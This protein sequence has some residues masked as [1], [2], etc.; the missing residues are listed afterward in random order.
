ML[1]STDFDHENAYRNL[2]VVLKYH[3][4]SR[5]EHLHLQRFFLHPMRNGENRPMTER[6][7]GTEITRMMQ[8]SELS[9]KSVRYFIEANKIFIFIFLFNRAAFNIIKLAAHYYRFNCIGLPT[10][11]HVDLVPLNFFSRWSPPS[12]FKPKHL[13]PGPS[14]WVRLRVHKIINTNVALCA[15]KGKCSFVSAQM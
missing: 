10:N 2:P 4:G 6:E 1:W 3:N 12:H 9:I 13:C 11:I 7:A 5:L 15:G 14:S 8:L